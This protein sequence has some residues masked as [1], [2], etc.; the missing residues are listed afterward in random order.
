M[1]EQSKKIASLKNIQQWLVGVLRNKSAWE[2]NN[3]HIDEIDTLRDIKRDCC[4]GEAINVFKFLITQINLPDSY[5][6]FLHIPLSF[7]NRKSLPEKVTFGWLETN[8]DD[9]TPPSFNCTT[10]DYYDSFYKE[11]L[12]K[13]NME[14]SADTHVDLAKAF[15]FFYRTY[16]DEIENMFSREIYIFRT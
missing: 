5:L 10:N 11:Q 7:S 16:F 2:G 8:L 12:M 14:F 6:I 3:L 9:F 15:N 4:V 13:C 1:D